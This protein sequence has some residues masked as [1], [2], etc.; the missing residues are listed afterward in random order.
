MKWEKLELAA[1]ALTEEEI[2]DG[3][4]G[5]ADDARFPALVRLV[6]RQKELAVDAG[7]AIQWADHHGCLAHAAGVTYA[8]N[9][10]LGRLREVCDPTRPTGRGNAKGTEGATPRR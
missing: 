8:M 9:E 4:R 7:C 1:R 2:R 6:L 3:L 5:L 10:L